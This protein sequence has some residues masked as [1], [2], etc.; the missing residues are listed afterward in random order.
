MIV[1]YG[2]SF[3]RNRNM[4]HQS[5]CFYL[6]VILFS[7]FA[8]SVADTYHYRTLYDEM[9]TYNECIHVE[10][11]YYWLIRVLPHNYYFWRFVVWG[12][13]LLLL[14][15][16]F[17]RY[18]LEPSIVYFIFPVILLQQFALTRGAL[19][20]SL[21]LYSL[22][23][24]LKPLPNKGISYVLGIGGCI[25]ALSLHKSLP[26]YALIAI[27]AFIPMKRPTV[28]LLLIAFP[29]IRTFV[30]PFVFGILETNIFSEHTID[31]A[32]N[33][34]EAEQTKAN[35]N[36]II[37]LLVDYIPRFLIFYTLIKDYSFKTRIKPPK[38]I[39]ILYQYSFILFYI[40]LLFFGQNTSSFVSNRTLHMM[41]FPLTIVLSYF[42]RNNVKRG[43]IT[44]TA[45]GLFILSDLYSFAYSIYSWN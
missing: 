41:Y 22:S 37:R 2:I 24:I 4:T 3:Y 1:I 17:K 14:D 40:A 11:F 23:F 30:I 6:C 43:W 31:F 42:L 20:I 34:L 29:F 26:L 12:G 32:T 33:Y 45:I 39:R 18:C 19:G 8:F 9:L 27:L 28:C 44:N 38:F 15:R 16:C 5:T 13:A 36:G 25:I 7:T 35:F 10:P 21:F